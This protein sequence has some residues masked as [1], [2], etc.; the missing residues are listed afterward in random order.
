[1][2]RNFATGQ[3][4]AVPN[5][6]ARGTPRFVQVAI[7]ETI[8]FARTAAGALYYKNGGVSAV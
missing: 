5:S 8:A 6:N 3:W 2:A 1:M 4:Q 7:S